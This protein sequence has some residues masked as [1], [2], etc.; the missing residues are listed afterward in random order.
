MKQAG[1]EGRYIEVG[2]QDV[3]VHAG[4]VRV[5]A[6]QDRRARRAAE[7]CDREAVGVPDAFAPE[8]VPCLGHDEHRVTRPLVV[9]D[10]D[11]HV[12]RGSSALRSEKSTAE[13]E[14]RDRQDRGSRQQAHGDAV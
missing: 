1:E 11:E 9:R 10:D 12:G 2:W 8:V 6:S 14:R 3:P 7:R 5:A 13:D 4:V